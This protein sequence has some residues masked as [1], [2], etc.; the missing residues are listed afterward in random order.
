MTE[1]PTEQPYQGNMAT[2]CFGPVQYEA[3]SVAI[4]SAVETEFNTEGFLLERIWQL[5][6]YFCPARNFIYLRF[7]SRKI[8]K[9]YNKQILWD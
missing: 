4:L 9:L 3:A 7:L 1:L 2:V 5:I 8:Q 6:G